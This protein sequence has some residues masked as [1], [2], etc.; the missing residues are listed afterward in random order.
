MFDD[1]GE[2]RIAAGK[3]DLMNQLQVEIYT[4]FPDPDISIIDSC[5]ILWILR[6]GNGAVQDFASNVSRYIFMKVFARYLD[7][8][9]KSKTRSEH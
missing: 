7:C 8:S 5:A 6:P 9:I 3:S 1:E 4:R 2:M